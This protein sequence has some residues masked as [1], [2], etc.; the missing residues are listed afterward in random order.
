M[1]SQQVVIGKNIIEILTTGMYHNPLIIFREYIQNSIDAINEAH[2]IGLL[3]DVS[4]GDVQIFIDE[5]N[6]TISFED[7][8]I[9]VSA[10]KAW[11]TLTSI[12]ASAKDRTK[13]LGFRGIGRL[14][15][16]AY[17]DE[18]MIETSFRGEETKSILQWDG[19]K[20]KNIIA[21]KNDKMLASEV[22][23]SITSL[24]EETASNE[25]SHYL[26]I[27]LIN[28]KN[29]KLL[30]TESVTKYLRMVAPV[31]FYYP[32]FIFAPEIN[33][34]LIDRGVHCHGYRVFVNTIELFKPYETNIYQEN[35]KTKKRIDEIIDIDFF[36]LHSR[37][38]QLLAVGWYAMTKNFQ[39]IPVFNQ[40]YGIR[41]RK[42]NIQ[43]GDEFTFQRFFRE[44]RFHRYFLGEIHVVS[45]DLFPN[46]QRDYFDECELL[47]EFEDQLHNLTDKLHHM[48]RKASEWNTAEKT[49]ETCRAQIE[50]FEKTLKTQEFYSLEH[51]EEEKIKLDDLKTKTKKAENQLKKIEEKAEDD[52]TLK[53]FVDHRVKS[54]P[55]ITENKKEC[56]D[57][58]KKKTSKKYKA[59]KLS[60]LSK[61]EQKLVGEI[62][63][64]IRTILP[65][66]LEKVLIYKIEEKFGL[67]KSRE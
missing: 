22:I 26:K 7:N 23:E 47:S 18:L 49:I 32:R 46:G 29:D 27:K 55:D 17:C 63:E 52:E 30:D 44:N 19:N 60:Q 28:V 40:A 62:Y 10:K 34:G 39:L 41:L 20:L 16:L 36:E 38:S 59:N 24:R 61:K 6:R 8:G 33:R 5:N 53:R 9:G 54:R 21:D 37:D 50:K 66:D 48:C 14:A 43:I 51:E 2:G 31:N 57:L 3:E 15:G 11:Q 12:A 42:G 58:A 25:K 4:E 64:V 13:N 67:T 35:K 1:S 45:D 65:P 56:G